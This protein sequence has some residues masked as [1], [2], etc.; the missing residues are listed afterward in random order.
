MCVYG[1]DVYFVV[2]VFVFGND[3]WVVGVY[4]GDW[5]VGMFEWVDFVEEGVV[6]VGCLCVVF[7]DVICDDGVC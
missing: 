3:E 7:D 2:G 4:F 6:V 1:I 5:K